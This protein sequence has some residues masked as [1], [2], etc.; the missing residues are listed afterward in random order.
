MAQLTQYSSKIKNLKI[1]GKQF[2]DKFDSTEKIVEKKEIIIVRLEKDAMSLRD[3]LNSL[4]QKLLN[5]QNRNNSNIENSRILQKTN[6]ELENKVVRFFF[7][8]SCVNPPGV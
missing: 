7:F 3:K 2:E 1:L 5:A 6:T 8:F 4:Q